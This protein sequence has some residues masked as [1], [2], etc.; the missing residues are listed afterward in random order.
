MAGV[1]ADLGYWLPHLIRS[2]RTEDA[3]ELL[4]NNSYL[5]HA[6]FSGNNNALLVAAYAGQLQ[7]VEFLLAAG[8]KLDF[9]AAI[10]LGRIETL[11]TML[12]E[13]S[14]LINKHS[15]DRWPAIHIAALY[16][17][18]EVLSL[19]ISAG[20]D[21]ND[22]SNP[23]SLTPIFFAITEPYDKAELLLASG[24]DI[25]ARGKHGFTPLHY[26]A[27]AGRVSF[28]EFLLARGASSTAQTHGRQTAWSL[29]VRHGHRAVASLLE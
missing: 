19:L 14:D 8:A 11:R 15:P 3:L 13:K 1:P 21:V 12:E 2:G 20:A 28:V 10:A 17:S 5:I 9:I 27:K 18:K 7:I 26:A 25:N 29:A 24:A 23:K 4:R 22:K 6:R 16:G